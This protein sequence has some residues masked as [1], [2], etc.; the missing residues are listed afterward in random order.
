LTRR[1]LDKARDG[2]TLVIATHNEGKLREINELVAPYGFIAVSAGEL[3]LPEPVEDGTT[4]IENARIK[5]LAAATASGKP[6]LADDSGVSV[7]ALHGAPGV[8]SARWARDKDFAVAMQR[9][10]EELRWRGALDTPKAHFVSALTIAWPDG[11]M[12]DF[13]GTVHGTLTF[14][15]RGDRGFG[16][17]PIFLAQGRTETFGEMDPSAKNA[18]SHRADAFKQLAAVCLG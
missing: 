2:E 6:A 15:A 7:D 1:K 17:D 13:E 11:H 8:F 16:Y 4:Y 3:G 12:E 10:E 9:V 18:M 14:P 5:A